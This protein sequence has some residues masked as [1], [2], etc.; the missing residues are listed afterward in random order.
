MLNSTKAYERFKRQ[1]QEVLDYAVL[2]A[3]ALPW[4]RTELNSV[5][6]SGAKCL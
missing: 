3:Y 1:S 2:L 5:I 4:F 6:Q